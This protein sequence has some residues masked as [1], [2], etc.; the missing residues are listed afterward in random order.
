MEIEKSK[1]YLT[2][3]DI[4]AYFIAFNLSNYL[5][6][7]VIR[8]QYFQRDTV[9]KQFTEAVDSISA[10]IAEGFGRYG[11]KDKVRFYRI[12]MGSTLEGVDWNNKSD[13]QKLLKEFQYEHIKTEL[14]KLP[15]SINSLILYTNKVLT[16]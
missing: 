1:K 16:F 8:W 15:R 9:G 3:N 7:I 2:L 10:N 6:D 11:K 13:V 4:E 14:D 12:A 5:W